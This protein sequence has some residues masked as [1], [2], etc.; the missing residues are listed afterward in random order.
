MKN[1]LNLEQS[2]LNKNNQRSKYNAINWVNFQF[3][4]IENHLIQ[5]NIPAAGFTI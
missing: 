1:L 3:Y 4:T 5:L 2:S